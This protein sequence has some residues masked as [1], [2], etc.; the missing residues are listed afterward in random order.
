MK[1]GNCKFEEIYEDINCN[2][3]FDIDCEIERAEKLIN[4][5]SKPKCQKNLHLHIKNFSFR[6]DKIEKFFTKVKKSTQKL[7]QR[8]QSKISKYINQVKQAQSNEELELEDEENLNDLQLKDKRKKQIN[9]LIESTQKIHEE[10]AIFVKDFTYYFKMFDN[11]L[12]KRD[13][14]QERMKSYIDSVEMAVEEISRKEVDFR[15]INNLVQMLR[16]IIE[17][18]NAHIK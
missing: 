11:W 9:K 17:K 16:V 13:I 5:V 1:Q 12:K 14:M 7:I 6:L 8:T 4:L 18:E 15:Q 10:K 2:I 3:D